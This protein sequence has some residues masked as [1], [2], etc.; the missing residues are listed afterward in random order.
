MARGNRAKV[1]AA[2]SR[3]WL[4]RGGAGPSALPDL[5]DCAALSTDPSW[6]Q[7]G[8]TREECPDPAHYGDFV[9]YDE[10]PGAVENPTA[11]IRMRYSRDLATLLELTRA[12]CGFDVQ[13]LIGRC[14]SPEDYA[15]GWDKILTLVGAR[16]TNWS[17][18]KI[19]AMSRA[20]NGSANEMID[21]SARDIYE[22]V[23]LT[24]SPS[25]AA[26][27]IE[28]EIVGLDVGNTYAGEDC[29]D[30][31]PTPCRV[32]VAIQL[33][34]GADASPSVIYS[35]DGGV[36]WAAEEVTTMAS[37]DVP[38]DIRIMGRYVVVLDSTG[39][40]YHYATLADLLAGSPTWAEQ[41]TGF[42]ATKTPNES[43]YV[44]G[45]LYIAANGGYIYRL[46][47]VGSAVEVLEA[48]SA[49]VQN[50]TDIYAVD[51]AHIV[52][53]G[54]SNAVVYTDDGTDFELVVG[55]SVGTALTTIDMLDSRAWLVSTATALYATLDAGQTWD[56]KGLPVAMSAIGDIRHVDNVVYLGGTSGGAPAI[57][58][59]TA[60]GTDEHSAWYVLPEGVGTIPTGQ[61]INKLGVCP[62]NHNLVY[63]AGL[64]AVADGLLVRATP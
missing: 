22:V 46:R 13:L 36:T 41:A 32:I 44:S 26:A 27:L 59:N 57:L 29:D 63:G 34:D 18:E 19:S 5:L 53:V 33:G 4:L 14:Q 8:I 55:P 25:L 42:V 15:G 40:S 24:F 50:L 9:V 2:D 39:N 61:R 58:R 17:A 20:D 31:C 37:T 43:I 7:G 16:V 3:I 12:R 35:G 6:A 38:T 1:R 23:P 56:Q 11:G 48:G 64:G 21:F 62:T 51:N 45:N 49:T 30:P 60:G 10:I 28:R 52:A 54:A 47:G